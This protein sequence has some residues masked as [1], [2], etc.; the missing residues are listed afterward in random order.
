MFLVSD[1]E[2]SKRRI[3]NFENTS[4]GSSRLLMAI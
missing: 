3:A 4:L 1:L 2:A